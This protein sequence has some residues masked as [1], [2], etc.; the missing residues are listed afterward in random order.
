MVAALGSLGEAAVGPLA[1]QLRR[2]R[3]NETVLAALVDALVASSG[4]VVRGAAGAD[5]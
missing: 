5:R 2:N 1:E 3:S 4:N